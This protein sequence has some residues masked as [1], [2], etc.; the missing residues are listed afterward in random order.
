MAILKSFQ[1][2]LYSGKLEYKSTFMQPLPP[3]C[4]NA[5][6]LNDKKCENMIGGPP[7]IQND[8]IGLFCN[9]GF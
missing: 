7:Q 5:A 1:A 8:F 9:S 6:D 4:K 2:V 3:S